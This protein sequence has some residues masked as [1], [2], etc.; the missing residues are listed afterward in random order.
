[1]LYIMNY[2]NSLVNDQLLYIALQNYVKI[3]IL[4]NNCILL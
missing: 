3:K 2:E 1:M 4:N